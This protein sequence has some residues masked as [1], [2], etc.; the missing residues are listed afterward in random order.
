MSAKQLI[1]GAVEHLRTS[2]SV[3][4]VYGVP[5]VVDGKTVIPVAKV[6]YGFGG[7]SGTGTAG[8]NGHGIPLEGE[9][10]GGGVA[11]KPVGVVEITGQETKFVQ[12]GQPKKLAIMAL[13]G[14]GL[15]LVLGWLLGRKADK[16]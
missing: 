10:A 13:V 15:G 5:I 12:F 3:K 6:A 2:A 16:S 1:D 4:T 11:A 7:G 9:G 14:T 8:K